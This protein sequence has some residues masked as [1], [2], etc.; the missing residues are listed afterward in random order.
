M[1]LRIRTCSAALLNA[2]DSCAHTL[3][4]QTVQPPFGAHNRHPL[5]YTQCV[6]SEKRPSIVRARAALLLTLACSTLIASVG[7][8]SFLFRAEDYLGG[9]GSGLVSIALGATHS[10]G[11]QRDRKLVC[12]GGN[13]NYELGRGA[14]AADSS[15]ADFVSGALSVAKVAGGLNH[16]CA[17]TTE[18]AAYCWGANSSG[19]LGVGGGV[20]AAQ[21]P[22]AVTTLAGR[23]I[24][25]AVTGSS[26][27][28]L[29]SNGQVLCWGLNTYGQLGDGTTERRSAPAPVPGLPPIAALAGGAYYTT[30]A[31]SAAGAVW[32]WGYNGYGGAGPSKANAVQLIEGLGA[33]KAV[34]VGNAH[35]CALLKA[36]GSVWCW[37]F[38]NLGQVG[39]DSAPSDATPKQVAGIT[40]ATTLSAG[41]AH[42]C[43]GS[44]RD[45]LRCWGGNT[46]GQVGSTPALKSSP[47]RVDLG[48]TSPLVQVAAGAYH[49][50][51]VLED[52]SARCWGSNSRGQLGRGNRVS[53]TTP[54]VVALAD[55]GASELSVGDNHSCVVA[56]SQTLC[57]GLNPTQVELG[58]S[59]LVGISGTPLPSMAAGLS[60]LHI[61]AGYTCGTGKGGIYCWGS[62]VYQQFTGGGVVPVPYPGQ[63][64]TV[65]T[66][67]YH[68]CA[69]SDGGVS[70]IGNNAYGQLGRP[71]PD[72]GPASK[73]AP[74]VLAD[75]GALAGARQLFG[76]SNH[77]CAI[78]DR[79]ETLCWG[80]NRNG[81]LG[82]GTGENRGYAVQ[83]TSLLSDA[84]VPSALAMNATQ[85]CG[86]FEGATAKC[87]GAPIRSV[88]ASGKLPPD[89]VELVLGNTH[90]CALNRTGSVV[91]WGSNARG[92]L[93]DGTTFDREVPVPVLNI[94]NAQAI[95][96]S[97]S[98]DTTCALLTTGEVK[99]WGYNRD[100]L[101]G[102]GA[103]MQESTPA[104]VTR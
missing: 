7:S 2:T 25:I 55:A 85:T 19:E 48:S 50:C 17:L 56:G 21:T 97:G 95:R 40:G 71:T 92:Q 42:T 43:A 101:L 15:K 51:A 39:V 61:G 59:T 36:D 10:C 52:G 53:A 96:T 6:I 63:P 67:L 23:F 27:C 45:G 31:L 49:T 16:T 86:L 1:M 5:G 83:A 87:A 30:C 82:D 94:E 65:A 58:T 22:N 33:A 12:W 9:R 14:I 46:F 76:V 74:V 62:S 37:G 81:Q 100:G 68:T 70:C 93:G 73:P 99:C 72:G 20:G 18:G 29:D 35:T 28:A 75:G 69:L 84:R 98:G 11:V 102:D 103:P 80:Y 90:A 47:T 89:L 57:W 91:C 13:D 79:G 66:G 88:I 26:S 44:Q 77:T 38:N 41:A 78:T 4:R 34:A 3:L 54:V 60:D 64:T 24:D 32:C 104:K 8:C